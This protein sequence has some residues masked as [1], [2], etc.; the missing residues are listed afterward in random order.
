MNVLLRLFRQHRNIIAVALVVLTAGA[1]FA[2][3]FSK[4]ARIYLGLN[5]RLRDV[6]KE[7]ADLELA[8]QRRRRVEAV[9][10]KFEQRIL[11]TGSDAE[12]LSLLL[13]ELESLTRTG[14]V[15]VKSI[16]ALPYQWV[17]SYRKFLVSIEIQAQ[18]HNMFE[19]LYAVDAST[20]ILTVESL[21]IKAS[22]A[23][24]HLLSATLLI[25]RTSASHNN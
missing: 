2:V 1:L 12:E 8:M 13:K 14:G 5:A 16:R 17:G 24:P 18:V 23:A 9:C 20:K 10:K 25:S 4:P 22:R 21:K 6:R 11:A 19:L 3:V 7:L 15:E